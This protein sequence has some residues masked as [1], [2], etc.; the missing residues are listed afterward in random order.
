MIC[1]CLVL[2]FWFCLPSFRIQ[3]NDTKFC[4]QGVYLLPLCI[5]ETLQLIIFHVEWFNEVRICSLQVAAGRFLVVLDHIRSFLARCRPFHVI[6]SSLLVFS[7]RCRSFLALCRS[8]QVV[9]RLL[10]TII[11]EY[12]HWICLFCS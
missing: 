5:I 3:T 6:S 10:S 11:W 4:K 8:F 2:G 12:F 1:F 9:P 7:V